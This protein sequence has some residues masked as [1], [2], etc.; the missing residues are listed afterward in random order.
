MYFIKKEKNLYMTVEALRLRTKKQ[1]LW[2]GYV[3]TNNHYDDGNV[4]KSKDELRKLTRHLRGNFQR[5][6]ANEIRNKPTSFR[7]YVNSKVK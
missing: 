1:R 3:S 4:V 5:N 2:K 6:I 7:K